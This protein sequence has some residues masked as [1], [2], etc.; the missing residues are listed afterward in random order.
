[1]PV[2]TDH[3][4]LLSG[5]SWAGIE[6]YAR[7]LF[8][9]YAFPSAS[10][11]SH[12]AA[13]VMGTAVST[14]ATL[15]AA[16]RTLARQAI[17]EWA[18][19]CGL[20]ALEVGPLR[21][22]ITF[23]W[24][25]FTGSL[26]DGAAGIAFYPFGA[27][28]GASA[29]YFIDHRTTNDVGGDVFLNLD[30]AVGGL[31]DYGLLL[32]ELGHALGFKHPFEVF[33]EHDETLDPL[34]DNT[35]N[36]VMSY[37]GPSPTQLGPLDLDAAAAVYGAA[38]SGG[39]QVQSW[40][41]DSASSLLTQTGFNTADTM[42]GV[43]VSDSM[44]GQ[45]GDDWILGLDG[46]DTLNGLAGN[47]VLFGG[48]GND[49]LLAGAGNDTAEGWQGNDTLGGGAGDDSLD[50]GAGNDRLFGGDGLDV[51]FGDVGDDRLDGGAGNDTLFGWAGFDRLYGMEGDDVLAGG[52]D[53]DLLDGGAGQDNLFGD[54]GNDTLNGG[55]GNDSLTGGAGNDR[56]L[57]TV[58]FGWDIVWDWEDGLDRLAFSAIPGVTSIGNLGIADDGFGNARVTVAG[59]GEALLIA[60]A[61]ST[62]TAADMLFL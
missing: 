17:A 22:D 31:P 34:L 25:D 11:T 33:G 18:A 47:D 13:D 3:T 29:P 5:Y 59:H 7:P 36:T 43:S 19:A 21:G 35:T 23:S 27:Y 28:T 53:K 32:H 42:I 12:A 24:Y 51:L 2:V 6:V 40:A 62:I 54:A 39:S 61:A 60:V 58:N 8:I 37:T 41:W 46:N 55:E 38:G 48:S 57:F 15:D 50:G 30:Y 52:D 26:F 14:F 10:P 44:L 4:A 9:T 16:D 45:G 49:S 56:F 1:M 20:I